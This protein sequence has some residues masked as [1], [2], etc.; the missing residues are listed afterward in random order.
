MPFAP[1]ESCREKLCVIG[2]HELCVQAESRPYVSKVSG[3]SGF[4]KRP[5]VRARA[6]QSR[7]APLRTLVS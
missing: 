1:G 7:G 5:G 4:E 2:K 6:T 3:R